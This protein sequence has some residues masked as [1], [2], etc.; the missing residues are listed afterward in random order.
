MRNASSAVDLAARDAQLLRPARPDEAGE[1]LRA[2]A[3]G[4]D[5]EEDLR[6][7]E[8]GAFAGDPI[9]ARQRQLAATAER[10]AAD[11]GDHEAV[12]GG[13]GVVGGMEPRR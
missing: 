5:A 13:D 6:L 8:H 7:A 10:V 12:E 9:V 4:N 1:A 2:A 3:A 11:G